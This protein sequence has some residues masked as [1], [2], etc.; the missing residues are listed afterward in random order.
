MFI[1]QIEKYIEVLKQLK[2]QGYKK[3]KKI[4]YIY[5]THTFVFV[6]RLVY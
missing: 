3:D 2:L 4:A 1:K 5:L 6:T